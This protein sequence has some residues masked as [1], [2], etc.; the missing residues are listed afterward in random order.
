MAGHHLFLL[1]VAQHPVLLGVE[2]EAQAVGIARTRLEDG[3]SFGS[4]LCDM[5]PQ[6]DGIAVAH[7]GIDSCDVG[8]HSLSVAKACGIVH[9]VYQPGVVDLEVVGVAHVGGHGAVSL[10]HGP[11]VHEA[12]VIAVFSLAPHGRRLVD[13]AVDVEQAQVVYGAV[14]VAQI[15]AVVVGIAYLLHHLA[16]HIVVGGEPQC[17]I[18]VHGECRHG[19]SVSFIARHKV[20]PLVL[21][22]YVLTGNL[23][24]PD[25]E[26]DVPCLVYAR[27]EMSVADAQ[28]AA[29][30]RPLQPALDG[31]VAVEEDGVHGDLFVAV[32]AQLLGHVVGYGLVVE[33][34]GDDDVLVAHI[35]GHDVLVELHDDVV[36]I[37]Q[38][39]VGGRRSGEVARTYVI[40]H[41]G[42]LAAI[43]VDVVGAILRGG[44]GAEG[45]VALRVGYVVFHVKAQTQVAG[46]G[47]HMVVQAGGVGTVDDEGQCIGLVPDGGALV[48]VLHAQFLQSLELAVE[49][50]DF[51]Y[52]VALV[53]VQCL[54]VEHRLTDG[55]IDG[56]RRGHEVSVE[57]HLVVDFSR[58]ILRAEAYLDA[59]VVEDALVGL[60]YGEHL[61]R[62]LAL[63]QLY[64]TAVD[65][66][67][68]HEY[69]QTQ[70]VG[71]L[72]DEQVVTEVRA[73]VHI[74]HIGAVERDISLAPGRYVGNGGI[75]R[76]ILVAHGNV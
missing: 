54:D 57:R 9:V 44:V 22:Q 48:A 23:S 11:V 29:G 53:V 8:L 41:H 20:G 62:G 33:L 25:V 26:D 19:L 13:I 32:R 71:L 31:E 12:V 3:G 6:L 55:E 52:Q 58:L 46:G 43:D 49:A 35:A 70:V 28:D 66:H 27:N 5:C 37:A 61:L 15:K 72:H 14:H 74:G 10:I 47:Q 7:A 39:A 4:T 59:L 68:V 34:G 56:R 60:L 51:Q 30:L 16:A 18:A 1:S 63:V 21:W 67:A 64:G 69:L 75:L 24:R 65:R 38:D 76:R 2:V 36:A 50:A 40:L 45:I 73:L 17:D 42:H